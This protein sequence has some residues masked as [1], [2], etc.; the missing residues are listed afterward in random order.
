MVEI[1]LHLHAAE[2]LLQCYALIEAS[3]QEALDGRDGSVAEE[4]A[5]DGALC[6]ASPLDVQAI[7][8]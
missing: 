4:V 6:Y 8:I 1:L 7:S 3:L 5:R 2:S